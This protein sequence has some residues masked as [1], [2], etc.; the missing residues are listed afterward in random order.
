MADSTDKEDRVPHVSW[1]PQETFSYY[2][3]YTALE[4]LKKYNNKV[5]Y[6]LSHSPNDEC[7]DKVKDML[8]MCGEVIPHYLRKGLSYSNTS[9]NLQSIAN[10]IEYKRWFCGHIHM[11]EKLDKYTVVYNGMIEI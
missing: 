1:W 2:D 7:L 8:T 11:D 10:E 5:D 4:N 3:A 6:V 9:T